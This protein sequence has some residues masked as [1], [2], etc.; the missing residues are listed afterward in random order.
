MSGYAVQNSGLGWRA[1]NAPGD[2]GADEYYSYDQPPPTEPPPPTQEE[3]AVSARQVRDQL[4]S[5][6]ALSIGP[7]QDAVDTDTATADELER[8][9]LWKLYRVGLIR[10][11]QQS[12]FPAEILWPSPP[13]APTWEGQR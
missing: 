11:E 7:L 3:L 2:V 1:I 10:I 8:L 9:K 4:L 5:S 6:A 13:Q 12:G